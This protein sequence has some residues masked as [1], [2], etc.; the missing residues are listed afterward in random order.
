M[1]DLLKK[2]YTVLPNDLRDVRMK[3]KTLTVLVYH[4]FQSDIGQVP[5]LDLSKRLTAFQHLERTRTLHNLT[6]NR[7]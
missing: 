2:S 4:F 3:D 1:M 6:T 5:V 7:P